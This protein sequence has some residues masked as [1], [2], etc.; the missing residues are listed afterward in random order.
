MQ[1]ADYNDSKFHFFLLQSEGASAV[2]AYKE[3]Q[4]SMK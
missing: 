1:V 4:R 3:N 2:A